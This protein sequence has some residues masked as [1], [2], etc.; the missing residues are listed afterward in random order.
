MSG[1]QFGVGGRADWLRWLTRIRFFGISLALA[2]E[3]LVAYRDAS[4]AL[5]LAPFLA[6]IAAW[7]VLALFERLLLPR[8]PA[9]RAQIYLQ[10][11][12]DTLLLTALIAVSGGV[13]SLLTEIYALLVIVA[14]LLLP[15]L[16]V[17]G[18]A[19][20]CALAYWGAAELALSPAFRGVQP[21]SVATSEK[22]LALSVLLN[23]LA[24]LAAAYLAELLAGKLKAA[25]EELEAQEH[26]LASLRA[27]NDNIV[28]S[29]SGGLLTTNL[30]GRIYLANPA[31]ER[32]LERAAGEMAARQVEE[33]FGPIPEE[34]IGK[35][36]ELEMR[37][38]GREKIIGLTVVPL[39]VPGAGAAGRVFHFQD[40]TELRRLEREVRARDRMAAVGRMAAGIAHEIRNPLASLAGSVQ[41]LARYASLDE[42]HKRLVAIVGRESERLN[43]TVADFLGYARDYQYRMAP[44][45]LRE[46]LGEVL[47]LAANSPRRGPETRIE[48][49]LGPGAISVRA[50][51]DRLK[52]VFWNLCDNALKALGG[53]AGALRVSA[54]PSSFGVRLEFADTGCGFKAGSEEEIFEPFRGG[55]SEGTGLGLATVYAIVAAHGGQIWAESPADGGA[56]FVLQL[57]REAAATV[58]LANAAP[59]AAAEDARPVSAFR[60]SEH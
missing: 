26:V 40:L 37:V 30:Q 27:L 52:Q 11:S 22:A 44:M 19:G 3:L 6:L 16:F 38:N 25:G 5:A 28:R 13:N 47:E 54:R 9:L 15:R 29:M 12:L 57:P 35:R 43:R 60:A 51:G 50:D 42:E 10:L 23:G 46:C 18:L 2:V 45:D 55:F 41:L 56:R 59:A 49:D 7:Y 31:A 1:G 58:G 36:G 17:Y 33:I 39:R 34:M 8:W 4:N 32:I 48:A 14:A 53:G 21:M 20:L 24:F